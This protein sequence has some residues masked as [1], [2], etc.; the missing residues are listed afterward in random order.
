MDVASVKH[1]R[2]EVTFSS[3]NLVDDQFEFVHVKGIAFGEICGSDG[4]SPSRL[5]APTIRQ[6]HDFQPFDKRMIFNHSASS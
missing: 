3:A 5:V 6:A 4:A 1:W 2:Q